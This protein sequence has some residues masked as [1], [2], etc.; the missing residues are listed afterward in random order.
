VGAS[1]SEAALGDAHKKK[2]QDRI[3][4]MPYFNRATFAGGKAMSRKEAVMLASRTLAVLLTV[5]AMTE[6][7]YLPESVHSFLHYLNPGST[8]STA[9]E[10]WRHYYLIRLGFLVTR[11]VGYSLMAMWLYKG[12]P[13]IEE[14]LLPEPEEHVA[15]TLSAETTKENHIR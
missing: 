4:A 1:S 3:P 8:S 5:S 6:V 10:Y 15:S 13:E 11:I 7:S 2:M 9:V 14:L 12:G